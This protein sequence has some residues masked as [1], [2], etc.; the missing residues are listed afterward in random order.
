MDT[1]KVGAMIMGPYLQS[2]IV[3]KYKFRVYPCTYM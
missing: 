1:A 2:I 3:P